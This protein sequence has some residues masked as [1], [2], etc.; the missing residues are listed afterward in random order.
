MNEFNFEKMRDFQKIA[1]LDCETPESALLSVSN[2]LGLTRTDLIDFINQFD[3]DDHIEKYG[4]TA[5]TP[6][7]IVLKSL[8][9]QT[10]CNWGF[11]HTAW[12]HMTRCL[13]TTKFEQ[14]LKPLLDT[15]DDIWELLFEINPSPIERSEWDKYR[16]L[17]ETDPSAS[18]LGYYYNRI[19]TPGQQGPYAI[20]V[21]E[22]RSG[23]V[24]GVCT[25]DHY[26]KEAP[27]IVICICKRASD[28]LKEY[29]K[30]TKPCIVKF[31]TTDCILE[32]LS[33]ALYYVYEREQSEPQFDNTYNA[34][35]SGRGTLIHPDQIKEVM[36]LENM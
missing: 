31:E 14:G 30:V 32:Y 34:G 4:L 11:S 1:T 5:D 18:H 25:Q 26:L 29:I 21:N 20:L 27:E 16:K 36:F 23:G 35:Y 12:F 3:L 13:P 15:I 10:N 7:D 17:L 2:I 19:N 24:G 22:L 9:T 33:T 8:L 28:L 6:A